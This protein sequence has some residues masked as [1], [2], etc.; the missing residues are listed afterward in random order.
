MPEG[1]VQLAAGIN[2]LAENQSLLLTHMAGAGQPNTA[3]ERAVMGS[4]GAQALLGIRGVFG[5]EALKQ[6]QQTDPLAFINWIVSARG[7]VARSWRRYIGDQ[8]A[9]KGHRV[10]MLVMWTIGCALDLSLIH[11]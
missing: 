6:E 2:K 11:I 8:C 4:G 5:M 10:I 7:R 1:V 9:L 3:V